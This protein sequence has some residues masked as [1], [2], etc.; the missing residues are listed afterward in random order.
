M[1]D[2]PLH[3]WLRFSGPWVLLAIVCW[4]GAIGCATMPYRYGK[5]RSSEND[6]PSDVVFEYGRPQKT[7]DG[8]ARMTGAWSRIL[9]MNSHVNEHNLSEGTKAKLIAYLEENDLAD[10][11]VRVNQYDPKGEW[12]RLREN[13]RVG[14]GWRYTF[15]LLSMAQY[16]LIPGRVFG[17]DQ[18]NPFTNSLYLNSDVSAV[19]L[20]EAAFA[21][22]VHSRSLPGSYAVFN[23][24]PILSLWRHTR[25]VNDV[26]GYALTNDD[27]AVERETYRVVYPQMGVHAAALTG[28]FVPFWDGLLLTVAGAAAGHATGRIAIAQRTEERNQLREESGVEEESEPKPAFAENLGDDHSPS[29]IRFT[30]HQME[31]PVD[32]EQP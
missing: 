26:L 28:S 9:S 13:Q 32:D 2:E 19:V 21:K 7:L 25:G 30:S 6:S 8:I 27:W 16:A 12:R 17:G 22:D 31:L 18:Y 1:C 11:L 4:L 5:F 15:G 3:K 20:H 10:V 29:P 23:E 14:L 24:F